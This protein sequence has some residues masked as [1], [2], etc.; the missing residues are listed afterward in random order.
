ME[1]S[2]DSAAVLINL[3]ALPKSAGSEAYYMEYVETLTDGLKR[4][5]LIRGSGREVITAFAE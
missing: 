1:R 5:I 2:A 3:P 4:V